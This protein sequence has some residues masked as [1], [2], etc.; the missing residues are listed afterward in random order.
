MS[1]V[2]AAG[3]LSV[4]TK[5]R[6]GQLARDLNVAVPPDAQKSSRV[7]TI[8]DVQSALDGLLP[9]L[10]RDELRA[11]CRAHRLDHK[12]RSRA[13][14]MARLGV[15]P[16]QSRPEPERQ[17][18]YELGLPFAGDIAVVRHRQYMVTSVH[19]APRPGQQTLVKLVCLDDDAAGRELGVFW[20][21]ELGARVIEPETKGLGTIAKLDPPR[22]FAAYL[23]ALQWNAVT[24]TDGKLFQAP[25]RAGIKLM[26]HQ[27]VPLMKALELP[28][29]NLF[30]ADDVGLGKTIEAGLVMQE[31]LLRQRIDQILIA[32]PASVCLQ[33][34]GEMEKRFGLRFEIYNRAFVGRRRQE[35]GFGVNAWSTYPRF[36]ISLQT[37][38]RP[39]YRDLLL[40]HL[41]DRAKRSLLVV[42]EAH[43]A[44]PA[45]ATK[46]AIDS[47]ITRVVRDVAPRFEH[48][49]FLSATPHNG[50]S[51]SFSSLLEILD[52]QRFTRGVPV[53]DRAILEEVMVRRLK[54]DIKALELSDDYPDRNVVA[55]ALSASEPGAKRSAWVAH[56]GSE[57]PL[58]EAGTADLA[59]ADML[60]RYA[61]VAQAKGKRGRLAI[62]NL[63]KRLLSSIEAFART[64]RR[65]ARSVTPKLDALE[66]LESAAREQSSMFAAESAALSEEYGSEDDSEAE[67]ARAD[68]LA[69]TAPASAGTLIAEMLDLA[70]RHR[71]A[72]SPKVLALIDWIQ[73]NQCEAVALGGVKR[74]TGN[75]RKR[76]NDTRLIIFTEY[77]DTK[78]WL[79][80]QLESAIAGT[81]RAELRIMEF[82]GG[83][84]DIQREEVQRAFNGPPETYPVRILVCTDAAREGVNLQGHCANLFHFDIPWN[85]GRI[86][87]RNGRIDRTLQQARDVYCHYFVYPQRVE[88]RV[89]EVL[90]K[91]VDRIQ[92]ELGSL[93]TV[94]AQKLGDALEEGIDEQSFDALDSA[95]S[96]GGA[97]E[98]FI[99]TAQEELEAFAETERHRADLE[100]ASRIL[101]RSRSVAS[102][103]IE[104]L[105]DAI[106]V[107]L[108]MASAQ[109]LSP[110]SDLPERYH[111]PEMSPDW[112]RT[113]D[114]L[115]PPR[116]R[117]QD[118]WDWRNQSPL[119][120]VFTAPTS[121]TLD[122]VHLHL[123]H[124]FVQRILGR[125]MAQGYAAN[126]LSRVTVVA[127]DRD[128]LTRV[129]AFGRLT[130]YGQGASRLH[131]E[132]IAVSARWI[133]PTAGRGQLKPFAEEAD[134]K[135]I[136]QL[137]S[138]LAR[139]PELT[140]SDAVQARLC[141]VA[142]DDFSTLWPHVKAEAEARMHDARQKL[143]AR[144]SHEAEQLK[145]ILQRQRQAIAQRIADKT[146]LELFSD[147]DKRQ[148][149]QYENDLKHMRRRLD[150]ME[151]ELDSEPAA[152]EQSYQPA[153]HRLE[154]VG[155]VYLWPATR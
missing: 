139:A 136:E 84:S 98:Q 111:L 37:L 82:H 3:V 53:K 140:V 70:E 117:D 123:R 5:A 141:A 45:S 25:F 134:R 47:N 41:G 35:R 38:R 95:E 78:R 76:W 71:G 86:E 79:R 56:D 97:V 33:W 62:V 42:D 75:A 110:D 66:A 143:A 152:I 125:F 92:R 149:K 55:V 29:V 14:L 34:R 138:L 88:D 90:V 127:N 31:L 119:P 67:D 87:Q 147:T 100:E 151:A 49:L 137:D 96:L 124:P 46:Y 44:A 36:I 118:F 2:T 58:G 155:L 27:L 22:H 12:G 83:M 103:S 64:L 59:L 8:L 150:E 39:E 115:R 130:L 153:L 43:N 93:G 116:H 18:H 16:R 10:T 81:E 91:K 106:D 63:Q 145:L 74:G 114:T 129:I 109:P 80:H 104:H 65:H 60:R 121:M 1:E 9:R 85:P 11:A 28:R 20:E 142:P 30:I 73:R 135:A 52:P 13:E 107:G 32:C 23:H 68:N 94:I 133:D 40:A 6:L 101:N 69:V 128:A 131:E 51:N 148:R 61:G 113:L 154:P 99:Q 112:Q 144:G 4:L 105:R 126:D 77:A 132:V 146:Q 24:S 19:P 7:A 21:R 17:L 72:P 57:R 89:L 50:H 26:R 15:E 102:F 108:Q 120:V 54:R 122:I 48:R